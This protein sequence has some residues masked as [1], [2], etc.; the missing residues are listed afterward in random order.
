[1]ELDK[2]FDFHKTKE[3]VLHKNVALKKIVK[4]MH[5]LTLPRMLQH[6]VSE[7]CSKKR[8]KQRTFFPVG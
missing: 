4:Y 5:I 3:K 6:L 2:Y 8:G 7:I 1:M